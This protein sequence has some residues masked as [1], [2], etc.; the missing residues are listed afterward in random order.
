MDELTIL[1]LA[2][3]I[4]ETAIAILLKWGEWSASSLSVTTPVGR[5]WKVNDTVG[6]SHLW[7]SVIFKGNTQVDSDW[8]ITGF[9]VES[10]EGKTGTAHNIVLN[11]AQH[12]A[13]NE[14]LSGVK[15]SMSLQKRVAKAIR[16]E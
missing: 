3:S 10:I 15:G 9:T 11:I 13:S 16:G 1:D 4:A 7:D 6:I 2:N 12:L 8:K 14:F 5:I